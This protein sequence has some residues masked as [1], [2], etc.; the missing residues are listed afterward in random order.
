VRSSPARRRSFKAGAAG[1]DRRPAAGPH[2][3]LLVDKPP[4]I[5][6][7]DAV[8]RLRK[9]P[10]FRRTGHA[11]TLDPM[12]TGLLVVCVN[13]GT[14]IAGYLMEGDKE[15]V[16]TARLG[17]V[18]DTQDVTGRVVREGHWHGVTRADLDGAL[19]AFVGEI[20]Q[21]P[22]MFS[23]LKHE[24]VRLHELARAEREV[25]RAP[26]RVQVYA[27]TIEHFDPPEV[28]L[29]IACSK[30]TYVRTLAADLGE[31]LGCGATLS[32][33]RRT[34]SGIFSIDE[35]LALDALLEDDGAQAAAR[36]I[37][38][39]AALPEFRPL[40][41]DA[42]GAERARHG[43]MP[44]PPPD[45][46]AGER[47]KVIAP[48]GSLVAL[49]QGVAER[50]GRVRLRALRVFH[51]DQAGVAAEDGHEARSVK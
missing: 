49:A 36:L 3:V 19:R 20:T 21:V 32:A 7:H 5:T 40:E 27:M 33:L 45:L 41:L 16:A 28:T 10:A 8:E 30:G 37:P 13:E 48:A 9:V 1:A 2:G 24:G 12:A 39:P 35:A 42:A 50:S 31:A 44:D 46:A 34:R 11:G 47:V 14:K 25:E 38:L 15:Y 17:V 22:P 43:Q 26:R 18:T 51:G 23:A 29:R 4:G 6:S